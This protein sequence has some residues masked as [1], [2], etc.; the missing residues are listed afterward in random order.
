MKI[1]PARHL[2]VLFAGALTLTVA[3]ASAV[4]GDLLVSQTPL[5]VSVAANGTTTP[6]STGTLLPT[7]VAFDRSGNLFA[8]DA[9]ATLIIKL[10]PTGTQ[11]TF[12]S[13]GLSSPRGITF[14]AAGNLYVA[15]FGTNSI[16][17]ITPGGVGTT[18]ATGLNGPEGVAFD[19]LGN[20]Y[21]ANSGDNTVV[22]LTPSGAASVF[23]SG[24]P[25]PYGLA[26]DA[27]GTLLVSN[28]GNNTIAKV[29]TGGIVTPFVSTGL[30]VPHG[31]AFDGSGNLLVANSGDG[32]VVKVSPS[33]AVTPDASGLTAPKYLALTPALHQLYNV[34]TRGF[35]QTGNHVLIGGFILKGEPLGDLGAST[36]VIRAIGPE[37]SGFGITDPLLDPVLELHNASGQLIVANDN[38]KS[39][40]QAQIQATGLA[41]TDDR[42][43]A[44]MATLPDGNYTAVVRG[45][46]GSVGTA[47]VEV[48]KVQ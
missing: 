41:P 22:K 23:A 9:T 5:I 47:L 15:D 46:N 4:V 10:T 20:L 3:T 35:V 7:G 32:T 34:S 40:Q 26:F 30:N 25:S 2:L 1:L 12:V 11:T 21:V 14:D 13:A 39:S 45:K 6:V 33:G 48:Y 31:I 19:A 43:A 18:F 28:S 24:L 42:E 27:N 37:L 36:V 29:T 16:I 44:I 17:K 8:A 38:W